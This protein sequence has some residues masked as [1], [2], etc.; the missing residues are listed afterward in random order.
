MEP[1][2]LQSRQSRD[3]KSQDSQDFFR[4]VIRSVD[5]LRLRE[6]V[7]V[8]GSVQYSIVSV[9]YTSRLSLSLVISSIKLN[10]NFF[11]PNQS[12]VTIL[13][14]VFTSHVSAMKMHKQIH[15]RKSFKRTGADHSGESKSTTSCGSPVQSMDQ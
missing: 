11:E 14:S 3:V 12:P 5:K 8:Q 13:S 1:K 6:I 4:S 7:S 15:K 2:E 9:Q 10:L